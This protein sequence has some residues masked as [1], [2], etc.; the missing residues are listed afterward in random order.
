LQDGCACGNVWKQLN[1]EY[2]EVARCTVERLMRRLGLCGVV[3]GKRVR[4]TVP[5]AV[6]GRPTIPSLGC[7]REG[8]FRSASTRS[9]HSSEM[10]LHT[11]QSICKICVLGK[12]AAVPRVCPYAGYAW[13]N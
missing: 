1:R 8:K 12:I 2:I 11:A 10:I 6:S 3:R 13:R 4:T 5:D 9:S 7:G